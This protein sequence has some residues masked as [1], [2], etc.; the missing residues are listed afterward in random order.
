LE[1]E[2]MK[3]Y[4]RGNGYTLSEEDWRV[5]PEAD[6]ILLSTCGFTQ[7]A[8]DFGFD[9]LRRIQREKKPS[10]QVILGGCIPPINPQR[11]TAEFDGPT[12]DP[13]NYTKLDDILHV[14][15]PFQSYKRPN[16]LP[17]PSIN[18]EVH[19]TAEIL[20]TFDGSLSGLEYISRRL[21]NGLRRRLIR[22]RYAKM[23]DPH[24]FYIQIQEGCSMH[25]SYCAIRTAIGP[26]RSRPIE[27]VLDQFRDGL[28]QSFHH[29]QLVGDNAGSYGLDIGTNMGRL[30]EAIL[31][32]DGKFDIDLTDINPVYVPF[33]FEP[34]KKLLAQ[35]RLSRLYIPIQ[36]G[37]RRLLKLMNRDCDIDTIRNMLIEIKAAAPSKFKL[38]TSLIV[39][40][41]SETTEEL[42]ET[43]EFCLTV[44]FDWAWCHSFSTRPETP[45][46]NLD[47]K[48]PVEEILRR[49]RYVRSRL[50]G[51]ALVT[52]ADD[53]KGNKTCQG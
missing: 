26:L 36:S 50:R 42:D 10:A 13:Q 6:I 17:G 46:A 38:G 2:Q 23:N 33:I 53:S 5:D 11:V 24:T 31:A 45:A 48:I 41:P 25:C 12:F 4:L 37:N 8:E 35:N 29:I 9:T 20:K 18:Q 21:S 28:T 19:R 39:G 3:N 7:P 32:I 14:Q 15:Y 44:G 30:L 34:V 16:M 49:A 40:F 43:I 47:Q 22:N 1:V 51:K 27:E 52:T